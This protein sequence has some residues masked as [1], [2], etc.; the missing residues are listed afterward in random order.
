MQ[1]DLKNLPPPPSGQT[2]VTLQSLQHLPP[3][4]QGQQGF[5]LD[6]IQ[7]KTSQANPQ[8]TPKAP[9]L[10]STSQALMGGIKMAAYPILHPVDTI[11]AGVKFIGSA[12]RA[13]V[14]IVRGAMGKAPISEQM[15]GLGGEKFKSIQSDATDVTSDVYEGKKSPLAGTG[16]LVGDTVGGAGTVLG[17]EGLLKG[18]T[19]AFN[20]VKNKILPKVNPGVK[21]NEMISPK[22]T[23]K[24]ARLAQSQGRL[25][26]GKEPTLIKAGTS[27]RIAT[28]DKTYNATKTIVDTI[29]NASKMKPA[30]LYTAVDNKITETATKLRPTMEA[31]PIQPKTIEKINNDW[32][33][34]KKSQMADAPATEEPNVLKRQAKFESLLKKSGNKSHADLWDTR[35]EYDNSIPD[36]VK[37]SN[38]LSSE[39]LQLQK[40]EWLQNR[41]ILNDAFES[42][43]KPEFKTMSNLYE[44]KN[45][46]T[47]KAKVN[48]AQMSKVNQ[49]LKDNPKTA[50]ALGGLTIYEIAKHLGLPL[51]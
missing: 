31:E 49:F 47:A 41:S 26:P 46:L 22:P 16:Q 42:S 1:N 21:V 43:T 39:S 36:A 32:Q 23:V 48:E 10:L 5:T 3:P 14:D 44:A 12:I 11:N 28:S 9:E 4:P 20:N 8:S 24:E 35:I 51:P 37:K 40:E 33:E 13:P 45:N 34:I 30:E 29:P 38:S 18:S 19:N 25:Y 17:A 27:D 6:Q 7:N 50:K 2:G 15:T